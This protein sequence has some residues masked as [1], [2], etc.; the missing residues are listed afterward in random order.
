MGYLGHI[1]SKDGLS[2][3]PD[4]ITVIQQWPTPRSVKDVK[5]FLGLAR[6]Y[7]RFI[8]NYAQIAGLL[9]NLLCKDAYCWTEVTQ[10]AFANS[11]QLLSTAPMLA[12]PNFSQSFTVETDASGM[13]G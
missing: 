1:I 11:K 3:D 8:R 10:L 5:G 9:T 4:K 2:V 6:Y 12:F 13:G 7:R